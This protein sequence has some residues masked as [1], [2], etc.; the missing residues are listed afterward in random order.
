MSENLQSENGQNEVARGTPKVNQNQKS[1]WI[2]S[3]YWTFDFLEKVFF[4][5]T[6]M[7]TE[8]LSTKCNLCA[9]LQAGG[10]SVQDLGLAIH[11]IE[12]SRR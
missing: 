6:L 11:N 5:N 1:F 9:Y 7:H 10:L 2:L 4:Q 3:N 8:K 12:G